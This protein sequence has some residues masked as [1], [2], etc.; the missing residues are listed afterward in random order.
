MPWRKYFFAQRFVVILLAVFIFFSVLPQPAEAYTR[1]DDFERYYT[2][3]GY[4]VKEIDLQNKSVTTFTYKEGILSEE[5]FSWENGDTRT[6]TY[7][8]YGNPVSEI[9]TGGSSEYSGYTYS[10]SYDR[11]GRMTACNISYR[12]DG[13]LYETYKYTYK[14]DGSYVEEGTFYEDGVY[15]YHRFTKT[16]DPYGNVIKEIRE[17]GDM[18][19]KETYFK[20]T[21]EYVNTYSNDLLIS[22]CTYE[23][24]YGIFLG[25]AAEIEKKLTGICVNTYEDVNGVMKIVSKRN[26][27]E[28]GSEEGG[29]ELWEYDEN[30]HLVQ[31]RQSNWITRYTN[32]EV[33]DPLEY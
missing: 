32:F 10:N 20:D 24:H 18:I 6:I 7:D 4:L 25:E 12:H 33:F 31:H 19:S 13:S 27:D 16:Y 2:T 28:L 22:V 5:K 21:Y 1:Y 15:I 9:Y 23:S 17:N 30:G 8:N 29:E 11:K 14:A 3:D 26:F